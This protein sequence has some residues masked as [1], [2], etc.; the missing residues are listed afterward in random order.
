MSHHPA[1]FDLEDFFDN[2]PIPFHL[3][4]AD[5]TILKANRAELEFL[6]YPADEYVG[7][8][9]A[10]FYADHFVVEDILARLLR[11]E[12]L[13]SYEACMRAKDGTIKHVLAR[14]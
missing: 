1:P 3:V 4:G 13:R 10:E 6:G 7:R 2:G 9:I 8:N 11:G 5:G 12:I 14:T